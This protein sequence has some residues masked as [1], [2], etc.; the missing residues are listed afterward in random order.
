MC[1]PNARRTTRSLLFTLLSHFDLHLRCPGRRRGLRRQSLG[2]FGG[3]DQQWPYQAHSVQPEDQKNSEAG[4]ILSCLLRSITGHAVPG[5]LDSL[6][7]QCSL[8]LQQMVHAV[9]GR[10][11]SYCPS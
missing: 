4:L 11:L 2:D 9:L 5:W 8:E 10:V 1:G 6:S 7:H 3:C